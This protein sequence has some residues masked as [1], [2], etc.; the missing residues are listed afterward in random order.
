MKILFI[1]HEGTRTGAPYVLYYFIKWLKQKDVENKYH[2]DALFLSDGELINLFNEYSDNIYVYKKTYPRFWERGISKLLNIDIKNL[3]EKYKIKKYQKSNY[4]LIYANSIASL[5][6]GIAIKKVLNIPL[7]LHL[8]ELFVNIQLYTPNFSSYI[9]NIDSIVCASKAVQDNIVNNFKV[10]LEKT[11]VVHEFVDFDHIEKKSNEEYVVNEDTFTVCASGTLNWRKNP[12]TFIQVAL[13]VKKMNPHKK[14]KF[15]W[16]GAYEDSSLTIY[17]QDIKKAG[18]E[19]YIEI[20]GKLENPF[21]IYQRSHLF[22]M[23]SKEDPFPLVCIES[24]L[25][26]KP[27]ICFES[28]GGIPEMLEKGGGKVISYLDNQKMAEAIS[29][30]I[31]NN[32]LY[33]QDSEII[34]RNVQQYHYKNQAPK[35]LQI[36]KNICNES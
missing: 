33:K 36:I 28:A 29:E 6:H 17:Q 4:N 30:Y 19:N 22:L 23:T 3:K 11:N 2:I 26:G 5:K 9:N 15:L 13:M 27:I 7:I 34:K 20:Q 31:N 35:I 8:H 16:I 18:A 10:P 14:I 32:D 12:D 21:K 25:L 24:G 1:S